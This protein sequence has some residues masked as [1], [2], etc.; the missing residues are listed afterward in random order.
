MNTQSNLT[1]PQIVR[2][3]STIRRWK[4]QIRSANEEKQ[5]YRK[6]STLS[7]PPLKPSKA[8]LAPSPV[9]PSHSPNIHH[10]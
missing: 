3:N 10:R 8:N 9:I 1:L 7:S 5:A 6:M 4:K 2:L